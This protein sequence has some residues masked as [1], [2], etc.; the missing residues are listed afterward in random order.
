MIQTGFGVQEQVPLSA[1]G[2]DGGADRKDDGSQ[3]EQDRQV[4]KGK[5]TCVWFR[6]PRSDEVGESS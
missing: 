4:G 1:R 2:S 5:L 3:A 6:S